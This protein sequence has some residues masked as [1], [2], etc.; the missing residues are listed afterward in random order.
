MNILGLML[1][2]S[3]GRLT[4]NYNGAIIIVEFIAFQIAQKSSQLGPLSPEERQLEID[5]YH[6]SASKDDEFD[7][8][9][10]ILIVFIPILSLGIQVKY[11]K[12]MAMTFWFCLV[13]YDLLFT[14]ISWF[15]LYFETKK[16][17]NSISNRLITKLNH[18]YLP[19]TWA[20]GQY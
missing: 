4:W 19:V 14:Y 17:P 6:K 13:D 11:F 9:L 16:S 12:P 10:I 18:W 5:R 1:I 7:G 15:L 20:F 3:L 8:Q 2:V